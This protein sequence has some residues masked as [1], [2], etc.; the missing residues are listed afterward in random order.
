MAILCL[1]FGGYL[2]PF[3]LVDFAMAIKL[4]GIHYSFT[5]TRRQY[6]G[7]TDKPQIY[8]EWLRESIPWE[9]EP[10]DIALK[11]FFFY[12][13]GSCLFGNNRSV[14]T[15]KPLIAMRIVSNIGAL[16]IGYDLMCEQQGCF[17][18]GV[19]HGCY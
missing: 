3:D 12:F 9:V 15:C 19:N 10:N 13:I 11:Q 16:G 2:I 14:L 7:P 4:L 8:M 5:L 18:L 1:R 17:S 6:F